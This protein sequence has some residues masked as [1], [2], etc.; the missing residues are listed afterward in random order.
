MVTGGDSEC[1]IR[2]IVVWWTDVY[3]SAFF[4][5]LS[6][7]Y[8]NSLLVSLSPSPFYRSLPPNPLLLSPL[9]PL[10]L[11]TYIPFLTP[12]TTIFASDH[13]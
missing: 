10:S 12:F 4:C 9:S 5:P 2:V 1:P 6:T 11:S 13:V 8:K 7:D 3:C